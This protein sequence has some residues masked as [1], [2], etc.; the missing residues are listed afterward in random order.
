MKGKPNML[1][2]RLL[3]ALAHGD[4]VILNATIYGEVYCAS[5]DNA[6]IYGNTFLPASNAPDIDESVGLVIGAVHFYHTDTGPEA[7]E[8]TA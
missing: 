5:G 4:T 6:V 8:A 1:R 2:Y 7:M 3:R